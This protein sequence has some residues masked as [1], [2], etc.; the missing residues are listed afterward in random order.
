MFLFCLNLLKRKSPRRRRKKRGGGRARKRTLTF[1]RTT[2]RTPARTASGQPRELSG[3][4][5]GR[6]KGPDSCP[7]IIWTKVAEKQNGWIPPPHKNK[8]SKKRQFKFLKIP[9]PKSK[10]TLI[11]II[12]IIINISIITTTTLLRNSANSSRNSRLQENLS[13]TNK[14]NKPII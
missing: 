3:C 13:D 9:R 6:L 4:L 5:Q 11:I 14:L 8:Y 2:L 12:F 7:D 10:I 1:P